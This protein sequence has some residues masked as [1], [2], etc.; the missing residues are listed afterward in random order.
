[1]SLL[2]IMTITGVL[3]AA[4]LQAA[5]PTISWLGGVRLEILPAI[6]AYVALTVKKPGRVALWA[7]LAGLAHDSLSAAPFG[8]T[9][10]TFGAAALGLWALRDWLDRGLPW[11]QLVTGTAVSLVAGGVAVLLIGV[12]AV[13]VIKL[14]WIAALNAAVTV[15]VF[16]IVD[17]ARLQLGME[18]E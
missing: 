10:A 8:M 2:T 14:V 6:V 5:G 16:F 9:M 4:G 15:V 7:S 18:P 3:L 12:T 1:M 13:A 11:V 17:L